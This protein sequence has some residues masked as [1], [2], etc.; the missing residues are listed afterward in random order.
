[1]DGTYVYQEKK[2][3]FAKNVSDVIIILKFT[4]FFS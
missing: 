1:M 4:C 2:S 3:I